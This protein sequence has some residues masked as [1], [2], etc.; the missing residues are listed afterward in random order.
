MSRTR[1]A[2]NT[3]AKVM[4]LQGKATKL[5]D[6]MAISLTMQS[7]TPVLCDISVN[8]ACIADSLDALVNIEKRRK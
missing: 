8:L 3:A 7:L 6:S 1:D 5:P 2:I 4:D